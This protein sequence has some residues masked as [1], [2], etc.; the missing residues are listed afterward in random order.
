[1]LDIQRSKRMPIETLEKS[2]W[3]QQSVSHIYES[4]GGLT[5]DH[6]ET[7][8]DDLSQDELK[9]NEFSVDEAF[10]EAPER[11]AMATSTPLPLFCNARGVCK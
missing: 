4:I 2:P 5:M 9:E 8:D 6:D 11:F 10:L 3:K 7:S 1:M